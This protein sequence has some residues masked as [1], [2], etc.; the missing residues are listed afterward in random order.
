METVVLA[1]IDKN[2]ITGLN[3][4]ILA[5]AS[6]MTPALNNV[7]NLVLRVRPLRIVSAC[8][9]EIDAG[10]HRSH[11]K[12]LQILAFLMLPLANDVGDMKAPHERR[13]RY[14]G[15]INAG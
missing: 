5:A 12:E 2:K 9:Q 14:S 11:T 15:W 13:I 4:P 8:G 1:G 7:I 6:Y 3:R 10:A